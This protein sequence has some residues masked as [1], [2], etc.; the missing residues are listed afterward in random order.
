[1]SKSTLCAYERMFQSLICRQCAEGVKGRKLSGLNILMCSHKEHTKPTPDEVAPILQHLIGFDKGNKG[2]LVLSCIG[3]LCP[4][5]LV[6][7][8]SKSRTPT[9]EPETCFDSTT[10]KVRV[11]DVEEKIPEP[12]DQPVYLVQL[13]KIAEVVFLVF[14]DTA[15]VRTSTLW[16]GT[17][18]RWS[19]FRWSTSPQ[20]RSGQPVIWR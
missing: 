3:Q 7:Q 17:L 8:I 16:T 14:F 20:P 12:T 11:I 2:S 9:L 15:Q 13:M 10:G 1:M 19:S 4:T 18:P 6:S 5:P